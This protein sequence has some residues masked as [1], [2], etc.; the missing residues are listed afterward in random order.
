MD[1]ISLNITRARISSTKC[2]VPWCD[3]KYPD[4]LRRIP[5]GIR[6]DIMKNKRFFIPS[7]CKACN[8]HRDKNVWPEI[9]IRHEQSMFTAAQIE[10]MVDLLR[11]NDKSARET[12][13]YLIELFRFN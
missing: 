11:S 7:A 2:C 1:K 8:L 9:A 6:H 13:T 12:G 5:V 10:E 3:G 4:E